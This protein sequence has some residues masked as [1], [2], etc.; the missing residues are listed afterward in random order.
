VRCDSILIKLIL[1]MPLTALSLDH[2]LRH[3]LPAACLTEF[4]QQTLVRMVDSTPL[5]A[6]KPCFER[7]LDINSLLKRSFNNNTVDRSASISG[8][9]NLAEKLLSERAVAGLQR[10]IAE[11]VKLQ[12]L[13]LHR[14]VGG[15]G[16]T[17]HTLDAENETL[18]GYVGPL[19]ALEPA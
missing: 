18:I 14:K 13:Q 19:R 9:S 15:L 2:A 3:C 12:R 1:T 6:L 16:G 4:A 5:H 8:F 7:Y 17:E 11:A 10:L